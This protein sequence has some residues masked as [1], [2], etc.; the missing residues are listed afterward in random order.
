MPQ[1]FTPEFAKKS[2]EDAQRKYDDEMEK[3]Y[4]RLLEM[5]FY[6]IKSVLNE[7]GLEK[8]AEVDARRENNENFGVEFSQKTWAALA[9]VWGSSQ[10]Q[11][12]TKVADL[13]GLGAS[14]IDMSQIPMPEQDDEADDDPKLDFFA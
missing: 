4:Y 8:V 5:T 7:K 10:G 9:E 3:F 6:K 14:D 11:M 2:R 13:Y 1:D 12:M